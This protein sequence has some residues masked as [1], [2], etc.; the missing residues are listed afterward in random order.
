MYVH[1]G[2]A[3]MLEISG[4]NDIDIIILTD[5]RE[6]DTY[7]PVIS[8]VY[9]QPKKRSTSSITWN[10]YQESFEVDLHLSNVESVNVQEQIKV[11]TL[12][13]QNEDFKNEYNRIKLPYG[14]IDYKE[15]M[16]KKYAFF[17]KILGLN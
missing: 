11:F 10:F 16:R 14:K 15:Y 7:E 12:M 1:F 3:T 5:P 2:G 6:Y 9:G 13:A 4:Q 17:N 8:K